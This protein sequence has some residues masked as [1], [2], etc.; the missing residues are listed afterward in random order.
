MNKISNVNERNDVMKF[1]ALPEDLNKKDFKNGDFVQA[2]NLHYLKILDNEPLYVGSIHA[3]VLDREVKN[4]YGTFVLCQ[5]HYSS[6]D[7]DSEYSIKNFST[8]ASEKNPYEILGIATGIP[9]YSPNWYYGKIFV[10]KELVNNRIMAISFDETWDLL[11]ENGAVNAQAYSENIPIGISELNL[12]DKIEEAINHY[13]SNEILRKHGY[14][15]GALKIFTTNHEGSQHMFIYCGPL[16]NCDFE[17]DYLYGLFDPVEDLNEQLSSVT[18]YKL[19]A[20]FENNPHHQ[21][22][23]ITKSTYATSNDESN[24]IDAL[25]LLNIEDPNSIT[26]EFYTF[27]NKN[28]DQLNSLPHWDSNYWKV[29][30]KDNP[31]IEFSDKAT[32][33]IERNRKE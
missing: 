8:R 33:E 16:V 29:P 1:L 31:D 7:E 13:Y 14:F 10:V 17:D 3:D 30:I 32:E 23:L 18:P 22:Y 4:E 20:H 6:D 27:A 12:G 25:R 28:I 24:K 19:I 21:I 5:S 9:G 26:K 2:F 11:Y 15:I